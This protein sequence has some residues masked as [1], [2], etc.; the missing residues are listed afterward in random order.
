MKMLPGPFGLFPF[1]HLGLL[2]FGDDELDILN[3][4]FTQVVGTL[5]LHREEFIRLGQRPVHTFPKP[6]RGEVIIGRDN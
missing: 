6:G 4:L 3:I 2:V 1:Q 5:D